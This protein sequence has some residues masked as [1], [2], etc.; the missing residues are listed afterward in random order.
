MSLQHSF[1]RPIGLLPLD[2]RQQFAGFDPVIFNSNHILDHDNSPPIRRFSDQQ[3]GPTVH[4]SV[5]L[6]T[7]SPQDIN[8]DDS[9]LDFGESQHG[10]H[11]RQL[12]RFGQEPT[13]FHR[14]AT[15][16]PLY[17]YDTQY[18]DGKIFF[19]NQRRPL[20]RNNFLNP[21]GQHIASFLT[22]REPFNKVPFG[23]N[24]IGQNTIQP[25]PVTGRPTV[26][27]HS[28][29]FRPDTNA[30]GLPIHS[31]HNDNSFFLRPMSP[32]PSTLRESFNPS[33]FFRFTDPPPLDSFHHSVTPIPD[34][35]ISHEEHHISVLTPTPHGISFHTT[36][37][38]NA[39]IHTT[40]NPSFQDHFL[41]RG[42]TLSAHGFSASTL[43]PSLPF[44]S[45][46]LR[47]ILSHRPHLNRGSSRFTPPQNLFN[48]QT[49]LIHTR[50]E[51]RPPASGLDFSSQYHSGEHLVHGPRPVSIDE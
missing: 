1:N 34:L 21:G 41:P 24:N 17:D 51:P 46:T 35:S 4:P 43:A 9:F 19:E 18:D 20:T 6:S 29:S 30:H 27:S 36:P 44:V 14:P 48:H 28:T 3:F 16:F 32:R 37:R 15:P 40:P 7:I 39:I 25:N 45:S 22:P 5:L 42:S 38:P 8:Y 12:P 2:P 47:P 49:P 11:N 26:I 50:F 31:I 33:P 23:L 13:I 10:F